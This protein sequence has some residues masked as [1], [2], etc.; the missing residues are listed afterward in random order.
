MG[1][2]EWLDRLN[3]LG[4]KPEYE[5]KYQQ[6]LD[7]LMGTIANRKEFS[8][9]FNKDPLYQQYKDNYTKLGKEASMNAVANASAMTG[10]YGNSYAVTAGAQANQQYLTQLNNMIPQLAQAAMDKYQ[11]ETQNL[12]NQYGMYGDA[13]DRNYGQYRDKVSDWMADRDYYTNGYQNER[14]FEY[15]KDRDAVA[16]SQ[17]KQSFDYN[18]MRDSVS[19]SQWQQSFDYSKLRDSVSDSQWQKQYDESVRQF[20]QNYALNAAKLAAS[21]KGSESGS[22]SSSANKGS[23]SNGASADKYNAVKNFAVA[24]KNN[25]E[26]VNDYLD[27]QVQKGLL[28][29][30]EAVRFARQLMNEL[31]IRL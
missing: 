12:Y 2:S 3:A 11:M 21:N 15:Q 20:N 19:D 28:T 4:A 8:Y 23:G 6:T 13:E 14:N 16:D 1:S 31:N 25:G 24:H 17:W 30:A 29:E 10:G 18:K 5:S 27:A 9:D 26:T 22:G 7:T